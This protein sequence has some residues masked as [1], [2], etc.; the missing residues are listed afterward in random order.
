MFLLLSISLIFFDHR[1]HIFVKVRSILSTAVS[2][3]QYVV[4]WP[5]EIVDWASTSITT[6]SH[7]L[8]ENAELRVKQVMLNAQLQR[9]LLI[10]KENTQ[11]RSL[12]QSSSRL[13]HDKVLVAQRLAVDSAPYVQ[14]IIINQGSNQQVFVGQPVVDAQGIMGQVIQVSQYTSRVLLLN[15]PRSAI[16][17]INTRN[18]IQGIA[19]GTGEENTLILTHIASTVDIKVGDQIVSSG[20]GMRYP[21][22]YPVGVVRTIVKSPNQPFMDITLQASALLSRSR[23][24]LLVWP[25]TEQVDV[26]ARKMYKEMKQ[27]NAIRAKDYERGVQ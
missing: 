8:S 6:H 24:V 23:L 13:T 25:S 14:E 12:L 15:D 4:N 11:L 27:D 26:A 3:I 17:I 9:L 18:N 2:P 20:L 22:G 10:Q 5:V 1:T 21:A 7:L 16:P 19:V